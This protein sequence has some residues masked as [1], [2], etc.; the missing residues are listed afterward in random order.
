MTLAFFLAKNVTF[1]KEVNKFAAKVVGSR[2]V[3][4][5]ISEYIKPEQNCE[6]DVVG[7]DLHRMSKG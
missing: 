1:K 2:L 6:T 7:R 5:I 4:R 3:E